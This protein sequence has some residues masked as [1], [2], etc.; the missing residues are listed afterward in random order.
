[1]FKM[2]YFFF[3]QTCF[4]SFLINDNSNF[5]WSLAKNLEVVTYHS[6]PLSGEKPGKGMA[7]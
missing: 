5:P 2:K 4:Y 7:H 3:A 6:V 1:M